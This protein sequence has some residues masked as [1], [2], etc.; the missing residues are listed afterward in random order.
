MT[1]YAYQSGAERLEVYAVGVRA[2]AH[3]AGGFVLNRE[4]GAQG[5]ANKVKYYA[6]EPPRFLFGLAGAEQCE[7]RP[8]TFTN[9]A[10]QRRF[11]LTPPATFPAFPCPARITGAIKSPPKRRRVCKRLLSWD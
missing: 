6:A 7:L 2:C 9:T 11:S 1:F 5:K 3:G 8:I 10:K 4:R